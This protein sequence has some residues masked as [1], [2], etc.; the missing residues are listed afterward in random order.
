MY[1]ACVIANH[2]H[3]HLYLMRYVLNALQT[4]LD[5]QLLELG[6]LRPPIA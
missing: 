3:Y 5:V 2:M 4:N 6:C 1:Q